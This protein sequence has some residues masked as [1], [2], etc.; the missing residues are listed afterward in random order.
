MKLPTFSLCH[1]ARHCLPFM[2]LLFAPDLMAA[3]VAWLRSPFITPPQAAKRIALVIWKHGM[4]ILI[5]EG[6]V[7]GV[8]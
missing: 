1:L 2:L 8:L 4:L 5:G 7:W 3:C 6:E